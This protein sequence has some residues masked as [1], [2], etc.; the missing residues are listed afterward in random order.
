MFYYFSVKVQSILSNEVV[1][2]LKWDSGD[3]DQLSIDALRPLPSCY[4]EIRQMVL[5]ARLHGKLHILLIGLLTETDF[6][7]M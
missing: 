2:I 3:I 5:P 4:R 6:E 1:V 7:E